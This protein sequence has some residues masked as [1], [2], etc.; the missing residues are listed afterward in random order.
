[1]RIQKYYSN[2]VAANRG[3]RGSPT[4]AEAKRDYLSAATTRQAS[5]TMGI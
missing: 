4:Y 2:I 5:F 1:M 3:R